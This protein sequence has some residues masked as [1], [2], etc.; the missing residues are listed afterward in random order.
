MKQTR[1][2]ACT[3][4][5]GVLTKTRIAGA[6]GCRLTRELRPRRACVLLPHAS[7]GAGRSSGVLAGP[8][9]L[10]V[11]GW[12]VTLSSTQPPSRAARSASSNRSLAPG[13]SSI[14][15]ARLSATRWKPCRRGKRV[16]RGAASWHNGGPT[17]TQ[18]TIS[19]RARIQRRTVVR[20]PLR[21]LHH[22]S[23]TPLASN[24]ARHALPAHRPC[25]C[26]AHL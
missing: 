25:P 11:V 19:E 1:L 16:Q 26:P 6:S 23:L 18:G 4:L 14:V 7:E 24:P 15:S 2:V 13:A 5:S 3:T 22:R 21:A 9:S 17:Q 10:G 8:H 12:P 20:Q